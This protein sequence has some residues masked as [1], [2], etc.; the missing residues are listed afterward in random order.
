MPI[1]VIVFDFDGTV[2]DTHAT[3]VDI[4]N[5]LAGEFGYKPVSSEDI[6]RLKNLS[7]REV[8]AQAEVSALRL[9][10]L[11]RRVKRELNKRIE[12][13]E[14]FADLHSCLASLKEKGYTLGIITSNTRENVRIFLENNHL[15]E[16]F[17]F[18]Y[19]GTPLF[20]KHKIIDR[21]IRQNR[22]QVS[23]VIYVGDETRDISAAKKS[24]VKAIAV[25]W[26]FNSPEVLAKFQ[27]DYLIDHPRQLLD[28]L[29][30]PALSASG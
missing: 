24:R 15:S 18:I 17:A 19:S 10:L 14:P 30:S 25:S 8:I 1:K 11:L 4:V 2:A 16:F 12:E 23:E 7:S 3:F 21:L 26:G 9:P 22:F 29:D 28:V 13:L 20:G 5:G 6:E 27:P